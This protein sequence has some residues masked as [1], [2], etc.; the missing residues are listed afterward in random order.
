[1]CIWTTF[2]QSS[3]WPTTLGSRHEQNTL[4]LN[5]L[6]IW[7]DEW[8]E[9]SKAVSLSH[10]WSWTEGIGLD[11]SGGKAPWPSDWFWLNLDWQQ[12]H[13]QSQC[14][15]LMTPLCKAPLP[16]S[17]RKLPWIWSVVRVPL[18][19]PTQ[20]S[21]GTEYCTSNHRLPSPFFL[22][23]GWHLPGWTM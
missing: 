12:N 20:K 1:M 14:V 22:F 23:S 11:G 10:T 6:K 4:E 2:M 5:S 13:P 17:L 3:V 8:Q 15:I 21:Q 16:L 18:L 9:Q 7:K 19:A